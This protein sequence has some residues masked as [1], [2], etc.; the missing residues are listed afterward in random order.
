MLREARTLLPQPRFHSKYPDAKGV[1]IEY[2]GFIL[3]HIFQQWLWEQDK[4]NLECK[5]R[6][7]EVRR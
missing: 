3:Q 6:E 2:V 4:E 7:S 5:K 1:S